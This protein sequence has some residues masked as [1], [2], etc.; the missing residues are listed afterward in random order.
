MSSFLFS[1]KSLLNGFL[2][3]H[4]RNYGHTKDVW[5]KLC[6]KLQK[7]YMSQQVYILLSSIITYKNK[8]SI[9]FLTVIKVVLDWQKEER[10]FMKELAIDYLKN[11]K[12][13]FLFKRYCLLIY[14]SVT[15]Y[16]GTIV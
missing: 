15:V 16:P 13:I 10:V 3:S 9:K 11:N 5:F 6:Y 12:R 14:G 7:H 1:N 2:D 8:F 4:L